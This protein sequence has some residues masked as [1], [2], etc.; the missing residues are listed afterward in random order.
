[1]RIYIYLYLKRVSITILDIVLIRSSS[2]N[3]P[4]FVPIILSLIV[5]F[6]GNNYLLSGCSSYFLS[7]KCLN[8]NDDSPASAN[9]LAP[10]D[11]SFQPWWFFVLFFNCVVTPRNSIWLRNDSLNFHTYKTLYEEW[12]SCWIHLLIMHGCVLAKI[13]SKI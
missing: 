4:C 7:W 1:M 8:Y 9:A 13:C 5:C 10:T 3:S 12:T 2:L 6:I 11:R